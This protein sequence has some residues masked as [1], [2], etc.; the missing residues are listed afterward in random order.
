MLYAEMG[1]IDFFFNIFNNIYIL[2]SNAT[3]Q[4]V[5][6]SIPLTPLSAKTKTTEITIR[7]I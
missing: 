2:S 5:Y 6:I 7:S 3:N 4:N 1:F